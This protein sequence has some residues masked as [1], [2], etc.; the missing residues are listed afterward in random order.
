[1]AYKK[2]YYRKDGT[3][4]QGHFTSTRKKNNSYNKN[5]GCLLLISLFILLISFISCS[6]DSEKSNCPTKTCADFTSQSQAQSVYDNDRDCYKN[7]D[8]DSDGV[9]CENLPN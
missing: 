2:G 3:Y 5:K 6:E 9:A 4:V 1:M 7:L 8:A